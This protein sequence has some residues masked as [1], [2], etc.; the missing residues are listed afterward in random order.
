MDAD[1]DEEITDCETC[2]SV[3]NIPPD[4]PMHPWIRSTRALQRVHID[5]AET[6]KQTFIVL[7][8]SHSKWIEVFPM[9][10]TTSTKAI[11]CLRSCFSSYGIPKQLVSY[12]GPQFTSDKFKLFATINRMKHTSVPAYHPSSNGAAE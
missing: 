10:S 9:T 3:R 11:E 5:F 12:N 7:I 6:N 1:I 4:A 8:D 2:Q